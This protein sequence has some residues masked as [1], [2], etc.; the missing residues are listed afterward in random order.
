MPSITPTLTP[1]NDQVASALHVLRARALDRYPNEEARI[2]RGHALALQGGVT[3]HAD[4]TASAYSTTLVDTWYRINGTCLCQDAAFRAPAGRC[5]HRWATCL[6]RKA[7]AHLAAHPVDP[8]GDDLPTPYP[9]PQW[10]RYAATYV[11]P[12]TREPVNGIATRQADG[13]FAFVPDG[14]D[15]AWGC[16]Y[17]A[18]ALGPGLA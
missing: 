3:L 4:G 1:V 16:D 12:Q 9:F 17:A 6:L 18:V 13:G 2:N 11:G 10:T 14:G 8:L 7:L 5:K 15:T